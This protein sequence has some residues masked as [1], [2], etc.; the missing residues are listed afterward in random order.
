[1]N[2]YWAYANSGKGHMDF[3]AS[4]NGM[5]VLSS[6]HN[7]FY[8]TIHKIQHRGM[9][10]KGNCW[11]YCDLQEKIYYRDSDKFLS[12]SINY[13]DKFKAY[14]FTPADSYINP[15]SKPYTEFKNKY[16]IKESYTFTNEDINK[17]TSD[18]YKGS[19]IYDRALMQYIIR[20]KK[21]EDL[22]YEML[23]NNADEIFDNVD[24]VMS[25]TIDNFSDQQPFRH[26]DGTGLCDTN[27]FLQQSKI[28]KKFM[29]P[30]NVLRKLRCAN[31]IIPYKS[32]IF[33]W[34]VSFID[35]YSHHTNHKDDYNQEILEKNTYKKNKKIIWEY[36]DH[37]RMLPI[38]IA[39][40]LTKNNIPYKYFDLDNDSY[41]EV[42]GGHHEIDKEYTS[43]APS[44]KGYDDRY[45]EVA[46]IAK[47][48]ISMRNLS[49]PYTPIKP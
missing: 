37:Q 43:N 25:R 6:K 21:F 33:E 19:G 3:Y 1:M 40:F 22:G 18:E 2:V 35:T 24:L 5:T 42:F 23:N 45:Q 28:G 16:R 49:Q 17:F 8:K 27:Y 30:S 34:A 13:T 10:P 14:Y 12:S 31:N 26:E 15:L 7:N 36:L 41:N 32:N 46:N 4:Y 20:V 44:W 38:K 9:T 47:E 48:Y 11:I 29:I 39:K